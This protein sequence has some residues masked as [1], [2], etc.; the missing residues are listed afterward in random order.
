MHSGIKGNK[1]K[2][3]K[4][5]MLFFFFLLTLGSLVQM[6][7]QVKAESAIEMQNW[8]RVKTSR[9]PVILFLML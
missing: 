2:G 8:S 9:T 7:L 1:V 6:A 5:E 4:D 3:Q